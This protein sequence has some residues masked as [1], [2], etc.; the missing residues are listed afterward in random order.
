MRQSFDQILHRFR[1]EVEP[2]RVSCWPIDFINCASARL[3]NTYLVC[4]VAK[5]RSLESSPPALK[6]SDISSA[7]FSHATKNPWSYTLGL[8]VSFM[9]PLRSEHPHVDDTAGQ[10][11]TGFSGATLAAPVFLFSSLPTDR[12]YL[13]MRPALRP[14][15]PQFHSQCDLTPC[16]KDRCRDG[17]SARW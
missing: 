17:H 12:Q 16:A 10:C 14:S 15:R 1:E 8:S 6:T 11:G 4:T 2:I 7:N 3:A 13:R 5:G 9:L